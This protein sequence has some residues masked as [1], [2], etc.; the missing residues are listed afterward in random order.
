[1]RADT[2]QPLR[3]FFAPVACAWLL[4]CGV[5]FA[6]VK[7]LVIGTD[8]AY[9]PYNSTTPAGTLVGFEVDLVNDLCKRI[10]RSCKF[11]TLEWTGLIP[12]LQEGTVDVI[13]SAISILP[14]RRKVI[15]FTM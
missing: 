8:G 6:Q 15:D 10:G 3:R 1:M 9:P 7:P 5:S 14:E 4:A 11:V 13:M 2:R 12:K